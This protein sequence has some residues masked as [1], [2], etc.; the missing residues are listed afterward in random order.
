MWKEVDIP[1][2]WIMIFIAIIDGEEE[3]GDLSNAGK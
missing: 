2:L 1:S 3:Y